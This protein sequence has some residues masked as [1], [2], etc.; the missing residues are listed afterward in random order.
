MNCS[1]IS[2]TQTRRLLN[3]SEGIVDEAHAEWMGRLGLGG[4]HIP[5]PCGVT[6]TDPPKSFTIDPNSNIMNV[7]PLW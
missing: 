4:R 6:G 2:E 5:G 3:Q 1:R 7:T